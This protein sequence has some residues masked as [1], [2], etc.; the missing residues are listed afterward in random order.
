MGGAMNST[1]IQDPAPTL[2]SLA[3]PI[4]SS[5]CL[6]A[7]KAGVYPGGEVDGESRGGKRVGEQCSWDSPCVAR[8]RFLSRAN[9]S[10]HCSIFFFM[11]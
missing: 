4:E 7:C 3:G 2:E 1:T 8:D 11:V 5:G 10:I 9:I 6:N